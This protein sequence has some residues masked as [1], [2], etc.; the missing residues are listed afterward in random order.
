MVAILPHFVK[1]SD[2]NMPRCVI[3]STSKPT[4]FFNQ[5]AKIFILAARQS[6][7]RL[8]HLRRFIGNRRTTD[9]A[10]RWVI[11]HRVGVAES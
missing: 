9:A 10:P 5:I 7:S 4:F 8:R 6:E 11:C 2:Q 3:Y 1:L